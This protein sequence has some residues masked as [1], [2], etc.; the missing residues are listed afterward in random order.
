MNYTIDITQKTYRENKGCIL[1]LGSCIR[2]RENA[3]FLLVKK[4]QYSLQIYILFLNQA[5]HKPHIQHLQ[6]H[7]KQLKHMGS[8]L[9][10]DD[11]K[12]KV[13]TRDLY[14]RD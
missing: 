5:N 9:N 8:P 11:I 10:F 6:L 2:D 14:E 13:Y 4:S 12:D 3:N 7:Y 1:N